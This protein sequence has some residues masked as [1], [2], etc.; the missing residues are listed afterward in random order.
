MLTLFSK[1]IEKTMH[2]RL[3]QRIQVNNILVLEEFGFIKDFSTDHAAFSLTTGI[4]QAWN[5]K[6]LT[7]GIFVLYCIYYEFKRSNYNG[8][9][10][11]HNMQIN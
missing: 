11:R 5:D 1:V 7:A 6:L 4:R 8:Y 10:T 3:N 2:C 9:R